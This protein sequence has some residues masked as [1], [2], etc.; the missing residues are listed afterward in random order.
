MHQVPWLLLLVPSLTCRV[1]LG[2]FPGFSGPRFPQ[3]E[4]FPLT[5]LGDA[6][7]SKKG[8]LRSF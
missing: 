3:E 7:R 2:S 5:L 4:N 6:K 1:A 8:C